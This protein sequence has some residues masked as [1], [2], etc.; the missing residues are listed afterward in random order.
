MRTVA[1]LLLSFCCLSVMSAAESRLDF[2]PAW[3]GP[4]QSGVA[5]KA[6]LPTEWS[7]K[8]NV[9]WKL[10][11]P[12]KGHSTPI[13]WGDLVF[14]TA[15]VPFGEKR[16]EVY[17]KVEGAHDNFPVSREHRFVVLA[18]NRRTGK[19]EWETELK[20][21]FPHEGGH[22]TASLASNSPVTDGRHIYVFMGSRGLFCLD[23]KGEIVWFKDMGRMETRHA[24]GEGS[25]PAL[26]G[27]VLV[28]NW[29]HQKQ[30]RLMAFNT[31]IGKKIWEVKRDEMTSWSSPLIVEHAGKMQVVVSATGAVRGYDLQNGSVIWECKGLSRNVVASPV[32]GDGMVFAANSYDW[33]AMLAIKLDGAKGDVTDTEQVVWKLNRLTPYVPSP[34]YDDGAL[35]FL[36]HNQNILSFINA[37]TGDNIDGPYRL[38]GIR[39]VF[40]SPIAAAAHVYVADRS[41][42][43]L[44]LKR[45]KSL[46]FLGVNR[47]EDKFSASPAAAG[48]EL[49]LRG[50]KF[51]YCIAED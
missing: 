4:L 27:E 3:R 28:V 50:E 15:A 45:D 49:Y 39:E 22:Y 26:H 19:V 7:E 48:K 6:N 40:A 25:S 47:L 2:W 51:L 13:I 17:S 10:A 46:D 16:E 41:G 43:T 8:K 31:R 1:F 5:P 11:L 34:L 24:Y 9:R 35:I 42:N 37:E 12:G 23:F 20:R 36:R 18:V 33:Q 44:V 14:V 32:A 30:S 21:E 38:G 29:D